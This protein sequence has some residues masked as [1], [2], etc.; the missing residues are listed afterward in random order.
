[1]S[2][3]RPAAVDRGLHRRGGDRPELASKPSAGGTGSHAGV[4]WE[5]GG[6]PQARESEDRRAISIAGHPSR[7]SIAAKVLRAEGVVPKLALAGA[8]RMG[9]GSRSDPA[10]KPPV[11]FRG[12]RLRGWRRSGGMDDRPHDL[13]HGSLCSISQDLVVD[14]LEAVWGFLFHRNQRPIFRRV[15]ESKKHPSDKF[16]KKL[17]TP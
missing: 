7:P 3:G 2:S 10:S 9:C 12:S 16:S 15:T 1:M 6:Q 11:R 5:M 13:E 17:Q 8:P 4:R 14:H